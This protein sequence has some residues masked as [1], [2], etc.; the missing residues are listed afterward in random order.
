MYST[1]IRTYQRMFWLKD[2]ILDKYQRQMLKENII[3]RYSKEGRADIEL[4]LEDIRGTAT[5]EK[6][7]IDKPSDIKIGM[8]VEMVSPNSTDRIQYISAGQGFIPYYIERKQSQEKTVKS[9]EG[10]EKTV[11]TYPGVNGKYPGSSEE[12]FEQCTFYRIPHS[13]FNHIPW[14]DLK[15]VLTPICPAQHTKPFSRKQ[16]KI[17][18]NLIYKE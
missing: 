16:V 18:H 8:A 10:I 17:L 11:D 5:A 7:R 1:I 14:K 6:V 9:I 13:K 3:Y 4:I 15:R 12:D 2:I